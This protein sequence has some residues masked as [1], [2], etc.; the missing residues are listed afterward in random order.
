MAAKNVTF[1]LDETLKKQAEIIYE[2]MGLSISSA[3]QLF[4][5]QTVARG[6]IPFTIEADEKAKYKSYLLQ[7]LSESKNEARNPENILE[8][9]DNFIREWELRREARKCAVQN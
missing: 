9:H 3:L 2:S 1:R 5:T 7:E 6:A 8:N 4:I